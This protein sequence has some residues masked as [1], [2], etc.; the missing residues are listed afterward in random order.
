[1]CPLQQFETILHKM[2]VRVSKM[3]QNFQRFPICIRKTC[4][5]IALISNMLKKKCAI[6]VSP[7]LLVFSFPKCTGGYKAD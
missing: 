7:N 2:F 5:D 1:M 3:S 4:C 6:K